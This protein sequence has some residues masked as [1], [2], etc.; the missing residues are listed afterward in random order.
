MRVATIGKWAAGLVLAGLVETTSAA[1]P[2]I[3]FIITDDQDAQMGSLD[4]MP[5]L[6]D[7]LLKQGTHYTNNYCTVSL[8]CPSRVSLWTGKGM[9]ITVYDCPC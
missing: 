2:N 3:L 6:Q 4:Y 5:K 8:C 7:L 9:M 1:T